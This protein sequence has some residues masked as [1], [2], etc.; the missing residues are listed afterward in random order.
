MRD[1]ALFEYYISLSNEL[2][3]KIHKAYLRLYI[4]EQMTRISIHQREIYARKLSISNITRCRWPEYIYIYQV[5][6]N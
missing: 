6:V 2:Y 4:S 3:L 1:R 5:I